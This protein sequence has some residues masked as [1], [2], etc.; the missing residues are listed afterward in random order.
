MDQTS[1]EAPDGKP[2][3]QNWDWLDTR[4]Y[5]SFSRRDAAHI[6]NTGSPAGGKGPLTIGDLLAKV[7]ALVLLL[8][9]PALIM[10]TSP[11]GGV[12]VE[13]VYRK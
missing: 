2:A 8:G 7:L 12:E 9:L 5:S 6:E 4:N 13:Q 3:A 1:S 10:Y 11:P